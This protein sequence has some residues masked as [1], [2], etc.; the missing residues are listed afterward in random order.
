[1]RIAL[2]ILFSISASGEVLKMLYT[3]VNQ[4]NLLAYL[5]RSCTQSAKLLRILKSHNIP[6]T[7]RYVDEDREAFEYVEKNNDGK[8][9]MLFSNGKR[10]SNITAFL[11]LIVPTNRPVQ[12]LLPPK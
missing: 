9:P 6:V 10:I 7:A 5:K 12:Y 1:M 8:V 2:L 3:P 4:L 11:N